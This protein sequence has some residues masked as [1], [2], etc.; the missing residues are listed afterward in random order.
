[1]I[2]ITATVSVPVVQFTGV[3]VFVHRPFSEAVKR[4]MPVDL[5]VGG[6]EHGTHTSSTI[7]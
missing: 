4:W 3:C 2:T 1:M 6:I 7:Y 5:Y